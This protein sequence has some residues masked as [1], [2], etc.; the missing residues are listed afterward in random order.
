[1]LHKNPLAFLV[2]TD[3]PTKIIK[4]NIEHLNN[5]AK[6]DPDLS[7][8]LLTVSVEQYRIYMSRVD[9]LEY[10]YASQRVAYRLIA[11]AWRF[12]EKTKK[13]ILLPPIT[14]KALGSTINL[15]REY[16]NKELAKFSN[17]NI[18]ELVNNQILI[19]DMDALKAQVKKGFVPIF[20]G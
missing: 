7:Y 18:I 19:K 4:Y 2:A 3:G 1:M 10:K 13:G 12:G 16:V 11:I 15:S 5:K 14:N 8:K 20:E 6:K 9:N 17:K